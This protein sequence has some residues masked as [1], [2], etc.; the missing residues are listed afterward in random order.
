MSER[1]RCGAFSSW[2]IFTKFFTA[3]K[4]KLLY[5]IYTGN[6]HLHKNTL[7]SQSTRSR[8]LLRTPT[9]DCF[10]PSNGTLGH[11]PIS[12]GGRVRVVLLALLA[13]ILL[14]LRWLSLQV[15]AK[16]S[17]VRVQLGFG[18]VCVLLYNVLGKF[19]FV[20]EMSNILSLSRKMAMHTV[21]FSV[22][23]SF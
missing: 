18:R 11:A 12:V 4:S 23:A 3:T 20:R 13:E 7:Q 19:E 2:F 9:I 16:A 21:Q 14:A 10:I 6:L 8:V 22:F 15:I 5:S 17:V 1:P